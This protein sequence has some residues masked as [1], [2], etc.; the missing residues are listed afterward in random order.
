MK[1]NIYLSIIT[2][3]KNDNKE[4]LRTAQSIFSQNNTINIEWLIID[5]S[6]DDIQKSK[7]K[8]IEK[9]YNNSNKKYILIKH[10]NSVE[11][12]IYGIYPCMN[13]GKK[14]SLGKF[15][16]FLNSGD[17]FFNNYSMQI[18][19]QNRPFATQR[20]IGLPSSNIRLGIF[21]V[22]INRLITVPNNFFVEP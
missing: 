5:G 2:L 14:I 22:S 3:S 10:I 18:L 7:N 21:A 1:N 17:E 4:F 11:K 16:I 13:Y 9:I 20:L 12:K 8:L 15:I 6:D 19:L